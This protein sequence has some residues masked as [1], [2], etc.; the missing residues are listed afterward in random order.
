MVTLADGQI[1]SVTTFPVVDGRNGAS[2]V[3]VA[4]RRD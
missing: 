4:K 1:F 3:Q 2:V